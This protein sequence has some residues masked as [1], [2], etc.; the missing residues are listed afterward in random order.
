MKVKLHFITPDVSE[1]GYLGIQSDW[2]MS[3]SFL[4]LQEKFYVMLLFFCYCNNFL[5]WMIQTRDNFS[6]IGEGY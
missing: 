3:C 5:L 6:Y 4:I 2:L 1:T